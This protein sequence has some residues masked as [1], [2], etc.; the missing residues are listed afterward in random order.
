MGCAVLSICNYLLTFWGSLL[1]ESL[2]WSS[3]KP[4]TEAENSPELSVF[5][6][7]YSCVYSTKL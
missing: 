4:N 2:K 7:R 1:P 3:I 5:T 6:N